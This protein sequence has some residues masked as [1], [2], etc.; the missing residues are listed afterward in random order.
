MSQVA[1]HVSALVAEQDGSE[2]KLFEMVRT[3][4]LG[5]RRLL[6]KKNTENARRQRPKPYHPKPIPPVTSLARVP[7]PRN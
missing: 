1:E 2:C 4:L 6:K 7:C 5:V 3:Q